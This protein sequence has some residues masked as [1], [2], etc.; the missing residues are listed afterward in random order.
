MSLNPIIL[1]MVVSFMVHAVFMFI[2][3][4]RIGPSQYDDLNTIV[5]DGLKQKMRIEELGGHELDD[6]LYCRELLVGSMVWTGRLCKVG[7]LP[8]FFYIIFF[9]LLLGGPVMKDFDGLDSVILWCLYC[10]LFMQFMYL[11]MKIRSKIPNLLMRLHEAY[12]KIPYLKMLL[13][14]APGWTK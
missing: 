7:L 8:M 5:I 3:C 9:I 14:F 4:A 10:A 1:G 6:G 11:I 12:K 13:D 2:Q